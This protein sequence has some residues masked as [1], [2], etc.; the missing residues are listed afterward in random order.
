MLNL[1][2]LTVHEAGQTISAV[3]HRESTRFSR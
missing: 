1:A 3:D 2:H